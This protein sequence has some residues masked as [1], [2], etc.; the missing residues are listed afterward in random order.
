LQTDATGMFRF[1]D[2]LPGFH[3]LTAELA[4]YALHRQYVRLKPDH[5][6]DD[7]DILLTRGGA[8]LVR[9]LGPGETPMQG[10]TIRLAE[11]Y[12][13]VAVTA[14]G[15]G[16]T[17]EQGELRIEH[18]RL[19]RYRVECA[20]SGVLGR[21]GAESSRWAKVVEGETTEVVF[22]AF[23][24][25]I[26]SVTGPDGGPLS[27]AIVR[28]SPADY[29]T[30]AYRSDSTRTDEEGQF[31]LRGVPPGRHAIGIQALGPEYYALPAGT[32]E[33]AVGETVS[34]P[35]RIA[36][37]LIAG[38]ITRAETGKPVDRRYVQIT[39]HRI[40]IKDGREVLRSIRN[41]SAFAD[42]HGRY[43]LVGLQPGMYRIWI[44]PLAAGLYEAS[45][46][47]ELSATGRLEGVDFALEPSRRGTVRLTVL[48]PEGVPPDKISLSRVIE[49]NLW[50][51]V[52]WRKERDGAYRLRLQ[53]GDRTISVYCEGY[54]EVRLP[55]RVEKG[56]VT[57]H[58]VRLES[59]EE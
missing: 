47:V 57:E 36:A 2:L 15:I 25:L 24:T 48:T 20:E 33:L 51:S 28:L 27:G 43:R 21:R 10:K 32:V 59:R 37:T 4:K 30:E 35:I 3:T 23:C 56:K 5:G 49:G 58:E 13:G 45:R 17:N 9:V 46:V 14:D 19:G 34:R 39:A 52:S 26:G 16:V 53:E 1:E 31:E 7:I 6:V 44:A 18:L 55:V 41:F 38:T 50:R 22:G 29:R 40:E 8:L 12:S 54:K 11:S 42:D